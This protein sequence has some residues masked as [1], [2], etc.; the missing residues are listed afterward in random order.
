MK[1]FYTILAAAALA[2]TAQ[3]REF[4]F[5]LGDTKITPGET[6]YFNEIVRTPSG[7]KVEVEIAPDLYVSCD[8]FSTGVSINAKSDT[9]I[10]MC[11]GSACE[12]GSDITKSV[13]LE[14]NK[15]FALEFDY[16][17]T[18]DKDA[19]VPT[20][21]TDFT[22]SKGSDTATFKLVMNG[23]NS[24]L[25][26]VETTK[27]LRYTSAGLEYN[28][29][30]HGNLALYDITGRQVLSAAAEG[31]GTVNTHSLHA[32]LYIY[33]LRTAAGVKHTG[34]IYVK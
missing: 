30:G 7:N 31:Q 12:K 2:L 18:L 26:I 19:T 33:S 16:V 5:W 6:V 28:I 24:S 13:T 34:K 15:K 9:P 10:Q 32:G 3:A 1:K 21:T 20:I 27:P 4:T 17:E 14:L 22:V 11:C 23:S 29:T 8:I 25:S